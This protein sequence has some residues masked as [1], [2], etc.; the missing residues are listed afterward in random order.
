T[1]PYLAAELWT[2]PRH[3]PAKAGKRKGPGGLAPPAPRS[4]ALRPSNQPAPGHPHLRGLLLLLAE[5][6]VPPPDQPGEVRVEVALD[7]DL[8]H[9]VP[10]LDHRALERVGAEGDAPDLAVV[11]PRIHRIVH[12]LDLLPGPPL[13]A[14]RR[15][16]IRHGHLPCDHLHKPTN[17]RPGLLD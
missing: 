15:L 8:D 4:S 9:G 2:L 3:L 13:V 10:L 7:A 6:E 5:R 16:F 11:G 14:V 17:C 12:E 1:S